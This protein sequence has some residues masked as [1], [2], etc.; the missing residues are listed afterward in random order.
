MAIFSENKLTKPTLAEPDRALVLA[1]WR[2]CCTPDWTDSFALFP[3]FQ[4]IYAARPFRDTI[5][6]RDIGPAEFRTVAASGPL[7][8]P[9]QER[10][11]IDGA[12]CGIA[13]STKLAICLSGSQHNR[14]GNPIC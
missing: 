4:L 6:T 2:L 7:N 1:V 14:I 3:V 12:V 9:L 10:T 11:D 5:F 8:V 13:H